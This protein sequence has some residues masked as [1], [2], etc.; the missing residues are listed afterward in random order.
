M[1][2]AKL[3]T[4]YKDDLKK[5]MLFF[6]NVDIVEPSSIRWSSIRFQRN[7]QTYRMLIS[8]CQLILEG[9]LMTTDTGEY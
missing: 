9:M 8:I 3:K 7:N 2:N 6:S 1:K 5:K 4:E